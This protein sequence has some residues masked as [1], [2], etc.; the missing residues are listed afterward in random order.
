V[1]LPFYFIPTLCSAGVLFW[2][3]QVV[4]RRS[5]LR[6]GAC[7]VGIVL[8][9]PGILFLIYY[10]HVLD[11]SVWFYNFR[12][13][14]GTELLAAGI[15]FVAGV[16]QAMLEPVTAG[17]KILLP[18]AAIVLISIPFV[19]PLLGAVD[20]SKLADH[21][22]GQICMQSTPSTCGPA[23][24]LQAFGLSGS[25][26]DLAIEALTYQGGTE[27]WYLIRALR[28]RGLTVNVKILEPG[29][30][31]PAP[32]I[33]GVV[34]PGGAGHSSLSLINLHRH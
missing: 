20:C 7:F 33:A 18:S 26:R 11:R 30:A 13:V 34:L 19:K 8:A 28:R 12:A 1:R 32:S 10:L 5:N 31:F 17:E 14:P 25:E 24:L 6:I 29:D 3:G 15:A 27:N 4:G 9:V 2:C 16:L 21:C 23:T 22:E